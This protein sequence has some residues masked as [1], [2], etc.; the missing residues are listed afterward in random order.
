M[1]EPVMKPLGPAGHNLRRNVRRLREDRRWS[2]RE[3]EER[4][5]GSGRGIPLVE[6]GWIEA[7]ERRVEV[8][9][10]VALAAIFGVTPMDLLEPP[11]ECENCHGAPPKGFICI[12][13]ETTR[14]STRIPVT[15][16]PN[17]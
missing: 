10:L 2:Y 12:E 8:D 3:M 17:A 1:S 6:L 9:E 11:A 13:C 5:A 7:G 16:P 4:L 15:S 14:L